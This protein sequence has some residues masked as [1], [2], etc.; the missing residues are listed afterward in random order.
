MED[1]I[2][3]HIPANEMAIG[4]KVPT[5]TG[6]RVDTSLLFMRQSAKN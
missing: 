4:D 6:A 1:L 3:L 5:A 2:V